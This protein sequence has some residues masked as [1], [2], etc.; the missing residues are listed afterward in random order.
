MFCVR[1]SWFCGRAAGAYLLVYFLFVWSSVAGT[2]CILHM[3]RSGPARLVSD[4]HT[5]LLCCFVDHSSSSS[6]SGTNKLPLTGSGRCRA[7]SFY[8]F[9]AGRQSPRPSSSSSPNSRLHAL[10]FIAGINIFS[11]TNKKKSWLPTSWTSQEVWP[12]RAY[13]F[14]FDLFYVS[15]VDFFLSF[16]RDV[17]E[18]EKR[19]HHAPRGRNGKPLQRL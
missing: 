4:L 1:L 12:E 11:P 6:S 14:T 10:I 18:K 2:T 7:L 15:Y 5:Y 8:A 9:G 3:P 17:R 16:Q 19:T 13:F